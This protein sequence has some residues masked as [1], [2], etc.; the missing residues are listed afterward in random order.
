MSSENTQHEFRDVK[1]I[2]GLAEEPECPF[3]S[4]QIHWLIRNRNYNGLSESGAVIKIGRKVF[5]H[6][7]R[8]IEWCL[9]QHG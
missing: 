1:T 5:L 6:K 2:T 7:P 8:F 3:T 9:R 4:S